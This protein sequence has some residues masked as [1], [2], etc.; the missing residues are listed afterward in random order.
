MR[1]IHGSGLVKARQLAQFSS[2]FPFLHRQ[3]LVWICLYKL[4]GFIS[5][6]AFN[7]LWQASS[8]LVAAPKNAPHETWLLHFWES[9]LGRW[10]QAVYERSG[11]V[12]LADRYSCRRE[13]RERTCPGGPL[14]IW[15]FC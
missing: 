15:L 14:F 8:Y 12:R 4:G 1:Q 13:A 3:L 9:K 11:R 6:V 10:E 7:R 5:D 2:R